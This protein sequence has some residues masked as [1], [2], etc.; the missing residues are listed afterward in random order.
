M[1]ISDQE[2]KYAVLNSVYNILST[3]PGTRRMLPTF[4]LDIRGLLF[5]PICDATAATIKER[6][7]GA[8]AI[9]EP[10]IQVNAIKVVADPDQMMYRCNFTFNILKTN[11]EVTLDFPIRRA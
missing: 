2:D 4:A 5:E 7:L 3:Q 1:D 9:W 8:I 10:R 6:I 11:E